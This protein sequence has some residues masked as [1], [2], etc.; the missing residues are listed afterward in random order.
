MSQIKIAVLSGGV[1][2][3]KFLRALSYLSTK[4]E[5]TAIVNTGDDMNHCG[6][7]ISPDIDTIIYTLS[8]EINKKTGWGLNRESWQAMDTLKKLEGKQEANYSWF[9]LGDRDLGTHLFRTGKL[10]NKIPLSQITAELAHQNGLDIKIL[11]MSDDTVQ[12]QISLSS[13]EEVSFQEYFVKLK[14]KVAIKSVRYKGAETAKPAPGVIESL[15]FCDKIIIA[16]SNPVLSIAPILSIPEINKIVSKRRND[17]YFISPLIEGKAL[18]GP[19]DRVLLELGYIPDAAGV[20][21]FY[22]SNISIDNAVIDIKDENLVSVIEEMGLRVLATNTIMSN[23]RTS[24][25]L[26]EAVMS[27]IFN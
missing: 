6:L 11:P 25:E 3:A 16:P 14:H 1:G 17:T 9:N 4:P 5:I 15:E 27:F 22:S 8:G 12:T 13:G 24:K 2:A 10:K 20:A 7:H 23:K 19:A 18:K 26:A 21:R